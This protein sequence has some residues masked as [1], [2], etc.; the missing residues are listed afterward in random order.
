MKKAFSLALVLCLL[1]SL[2][3]GFGGAASA[4]TPPEDGAPEV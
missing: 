4:E 1:V 3:A 2:F